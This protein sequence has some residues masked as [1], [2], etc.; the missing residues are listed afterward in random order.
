MRGDLQPLSRPL[1]L[2]GDFLYAEMDQY[3]INKYIQHL[4]TNI[5][6]TMSTLAT[7]GQHIG[8]IGRIVGINYLIFTCRVGLGGP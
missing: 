7:Y 4:D 2:G 3:I 1:S 6:G 8:A 5:G